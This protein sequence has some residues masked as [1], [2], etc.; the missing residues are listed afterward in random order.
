MRKTNAGIL[1][2]LCALG[3]VA[4]ASAA[5]D[6]GT[7]EKPK[8]TK[9]YSYA[10]AG[11]TELPR[12]KLLLDE[13]TLG[14]KELEMAEITFPAG[15]VDEKHKHGS[16]EIFYVL[17]GKFGH[18]VNGKLYWLTPGM[19]GVVRPGDT[20]RHIAPK[21]SDVKT[22]V[23]WAPAGEAK[24]IGITTPLHCQFPQIATYKGSGDTKQAANFECKGP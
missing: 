4:V 23:I 2:T 18:E 14:G 17:T 22:L 8:E 11:V 15:S 1:L 24:R 16:V 7:Q 19:V 21:E 6:A 10:T 12:L 20:V 13:A 5:G 3:T 9:S